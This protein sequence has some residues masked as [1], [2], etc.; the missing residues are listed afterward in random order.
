MVEEEILIELATGDGVGTYGFY[1][2]LLYFVKS[3][4]GLLENRASRLYTQKTQTTQD[5]WAQNKVLY[6]NLKEQL[7]TVQNR[8]DEC[9]KDRLEMWATIESLSST[10]PHK[11]SILSQKPRE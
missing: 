11:E 5:Q 8:L 10:P 2:S 1:I 9:E 6:D 4:F 3:I 7:D